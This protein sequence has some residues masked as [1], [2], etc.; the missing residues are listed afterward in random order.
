[1]VAAAGV[2]G[3]E[4]A[5]AVAPLD[6]STAGVPILP[7]TGLDF[8]GAAAMAGRARARIRETRQG[9]FMGKRG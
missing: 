3:E 4:A 1:V 7:F 9:S 8:D 6:A 2:A 5:V